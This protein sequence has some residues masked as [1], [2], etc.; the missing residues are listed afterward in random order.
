M[1]YYFLINDKSHHKLDKFNYKKL[2]KIVK[3]VNFLL[4]RIGGLMATLFITIALLPI[5]ITSR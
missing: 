3:L 4:I 2:S 5:V 1:G